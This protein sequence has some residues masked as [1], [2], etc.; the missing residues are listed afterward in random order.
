MLVNQGSPVFAYEFA[1]RNGPGWFEIPGYVWGTGHAVEL[2]YLIPDRGNF[3]NNGAALSADHRKL[4][5][6]MLAYWGAFIRS[7]T[8]AAG[9]QPEWPQYQ[10]SAGPVLWLREGGRT[11]AVPASA[12]TSRHQCGFWADLA[13]GQ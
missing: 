12:I 8:P 10:T 1:P 13:T 2:P 11:A 7:G 4:S 5:K 6:T 3:A 9:E